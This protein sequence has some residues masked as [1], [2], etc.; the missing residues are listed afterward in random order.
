MERIQMETGFKNMMSKDERE[1]IY[2][3]QIN[4]YGTVLG[5][6]CYHCAGRSRICY[7]LSQILSPRTETFHSNFKAAFRI[8]ITC[9][10]SFWYLKQKPIQHEQPLFTLAY[11]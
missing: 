6:E 1:S 8:T 2:D 5:H 7:Q 10:L 11:S 4:C 3:T 9:I